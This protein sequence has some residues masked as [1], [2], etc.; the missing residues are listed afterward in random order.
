MR[1]ALVQ[2]VFAATLVTAPLAGPAVAPTDLSSSD[3]VEV[4]A[5]C[6]V[7]DYRV[8]NI[9]IID[10]IGSP[11]KY[12]G[13]PTNDGIVTHD[14]HIIFNIYL[15]REDAVD[16]KGNVATWTSIVQGSSVKYELNMETGGIL[17]R[18]DR[19]EFIGGKCRIPPAR[20]PQ[21]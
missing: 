17:A 11:Q 16:L 18:N 14:G 15:V 10:A 13:E 21:S 8:G 5:Y 12:F 4:F 3:T 9:T 19:R 6:Y 7:T 2:L 1:I 20:W